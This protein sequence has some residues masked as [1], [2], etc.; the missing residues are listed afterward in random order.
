MKSLRYTLALLPCLAVT[1]LAPSAHAN[2]ISG[3][4]Y[5]NL[6]SADA[7]NTPA[8]GQTHSSTAC[9]AFTSSSINFNA[10]ANT[11]GSFINSGSVL[12]SVSYLNGFTASSNLDFSLFTFTGTA[13]FAS[14]QTYSATHDDGTVMMVGTTTVISSPGPTAPITSTFVF[15]NPSGN[16]AFQYDYTEQQGGSTYITNATVNPVPEPTSM[17]LCGTGILALAGFARKRFATGSPN[18]AL[19]SV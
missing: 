16:Y 11:I 7:A 3:V 6:S 17:A 13:Y 1:L 8:P 19:T 10:P 18:A 15:S 12:G 5:C 2:T 4:A 9:A 14:G